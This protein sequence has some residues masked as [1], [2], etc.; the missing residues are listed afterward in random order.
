MCAMSQIVRDR[1]L[2]PRLIPLLNHPAFVARVYAA[3]ALGRLGAVE[4]LP[5]LDEV[6]EE[7]YPFKDP[8]ALTSG[9]HFGDSQTVRWRGF[10]CL[11]LGRMGGDEARGELEK[12]C[13]NPDQY[14]DLRYCSVVGLGFIA[15]PESRLLLRR[16][17]A[18]ERQAPRS[19]DRK[20]P[21]WRVPAKTRPMPIRPT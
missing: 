16:V 1:R 21:P 10:L 11:A 12:L 6:I 15:S 19:V 18:A 13:A 20:R 2:A 8:M 7:G 17:A 5:A 3:M 4:A 14:R 9:K